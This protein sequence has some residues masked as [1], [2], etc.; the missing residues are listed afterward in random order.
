[1]SDRTGIDKELWP[2]LELEDIK[3]KDKNKIKLIKMFLKLI[4]IRICKPEFMISS[5]KV[6]VK[7]FFGKQKFVEAPPFDLEQSFLMTNSKP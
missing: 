6:L 1:M 2:G 5:V 4:I 3:V 7:E